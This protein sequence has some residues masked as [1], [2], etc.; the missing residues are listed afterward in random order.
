[1]R[2][3]WPKQ[4]PKRYAAKSI[5]SVTEVAEIGGISIR[6]VERFYVREFPNAT[7]LGNG[8]RAPFVIPTA[9]VEEFLK[10]VNAKEKSEPAT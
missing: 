6:A 3:Q 2:A 9:D 1:M 7:R 5:L 10:R 4:L 8:A